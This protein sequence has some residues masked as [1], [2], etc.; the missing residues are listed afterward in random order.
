M[1]FSTAFLAK[2]NM[3]LEVGLPITVI[4]TVHSQNLHE[5][6][7]I[8]EVLISEGIQSWQI[9]PL[10]HLGRGADNEWLQL[11]RSQYLELGDFVSQ[12]GIHAL[13]RGLEIL[14]SDSYGY[15]TLRDKREPVWS[16]CPAGLF[17]CGI[18]SHGKVKG[19][20]SL[21]NHLIERGDLRIDTL[22]DIWFNPDTFAY[23][24]HFVKADLGPNCISCDY[25]EQCRGGCSAMSYGC[26]SRFHNNPFCFYGIEN[27]SRTNN[28]PDFD[29]PCFPYRV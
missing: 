5:L 28:H 27:I 29:P 13:N 1:D 20:L 23:T 16:G 15:F 9:Q 12:W 6:P 2:V 7:D 24:R 17:S 21:P 14:P 18:T 22:W 19:C 3:I 4:T 25:A 26:T 11:S 10:F 8:L